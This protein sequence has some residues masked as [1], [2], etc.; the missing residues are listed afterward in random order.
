MD[1][2]KSSIRG[3]VTSM[4]DAQH[5]ERVDS[6]GSALQR[7]SKAREARRG[8]GSVSSVLDAPSLD[9]QV[10]R[11][12]ATGLPRASDRGSLFSFGDRARDAGQQS[13]N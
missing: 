12:I 7:L 11:S 3:I 4:G 8:T 9:M 13:D 5:Q 10:P 2:R 6:M 1:L